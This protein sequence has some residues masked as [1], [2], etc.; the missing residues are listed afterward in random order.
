VKRLGSNVASIVKGV[1]TRARESVREGERDS[2]R[3][4]RRES[5]RMSAREGEKDGEREKTKR[6]V[7]PRGA[8]EGNLTLLACIG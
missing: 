1:G 6:G 4:S 2:R 3:D 7:M 8:S 5:G